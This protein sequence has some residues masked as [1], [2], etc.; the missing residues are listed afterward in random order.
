MLRSFQAAEPNWRLLTAVFAATLTFGFLTQAGGSAYL[1]WTGDPI[2]QQY[3]TT[4]SYTS[5][6]IGDAI[7]L[8]AMNVLIT[9]QLLAWRRP[10]RLAEVIAAVLG[11][12]TLT[13]AVH[14]YQGAN[15]ILNWTMLAPYSWTPLGYVH[16]AFM[17]SELSLML[18]FWGQVAAVAWER[19]RAALC[20]RVLLVVLCTLA[21]LRLL[22]GD[23]GHFA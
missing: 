17:F 14:L 13:A 19:P 18:F 5:A 15:A 11:G 16:A 23:Y 3:R 20:H 12:A 22:L 7:L 21:F 2:A 9:L 1:G 4:L 10:A 8:P 6:L